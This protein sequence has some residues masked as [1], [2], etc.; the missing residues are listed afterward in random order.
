MTH[1]QNLKMITI[2]HIATFTT[3]CGFAFGL[4]NSKAADAGEMRKKAV[5]ALFA[6]LPD[7]MPGG[8]KDTPALVKL[9]EKLFEEK[10]MSANDSQSC[11][12][13]HSVK[14]GKAGVDN[15]AT[16][17]GAFG[18]RGGRNSP[19]VLNA[20]FHLAQFW[21]G[22]AA[23]L[24]D[25]AKGPVLNP[26][27]MAMP[28]ASQVEDKLSKIPEYAPLFKKA[29]PGEAR[30]LNYDNV[31]RAIAAFERTLITRDRFDDFLKGS[32]KALSQAE[33]KGLGL[34]VDV[35]CTTCH[36]GPVVGGN[37]FQKMGLVNPYTRSSDPG[38]SEV[39]KDNDDKFK[40]KVPSLRNIALTGPYFHDGSEATLSGAV[41][42]MAHL[43]LGRQL[44]DEE[45]N[46][47]AAFL[48]SMSDKKLARKQK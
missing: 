29:F 14:G 4:T 15:Q 37:S 11:A 36:N 9:G 22:R 34:F 30:P 39:T 12:S 28:S 19:T 41:K 1:I 40:F 13:C 33:L 48:G 32:D 3:I 5:E 21:D 44:T 26:I 17:P 46:S 42:Q 20:G 31:A 7:K 25:Q 18:K 16:S 2:K 6:P 45:A 8:E 38:R 10:R 27:E 35:G 43:Q 23:T 47:I 24:E